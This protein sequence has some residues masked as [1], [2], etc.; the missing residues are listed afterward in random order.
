MFLI[1]NFSQLS[2]EQCVAPAVVIH[3]GF[4]S[5]MT[6]TS[7]LSFDIWRNVTAPKVCSS[8]GRDLLTYGCISWGLPLA[9]IAVAFV[10][11]RTAPDST[12][13]PA[14]GVRACW[15]G[16]TGG[17]FLYFLAPMAALTLF[18]VLLYVRTVCYIRRTSSNAR[19]R[20]KGSG[21]RASFQNDHLTLFLRLAII[22]GATWALEFVGYFLAIVEIDLV[23][24]A[25]VGL[26]GAY[27][28]FAFRDYRY[29]CG[30]VR[31]QATRS[32]SNSP[33]ATSLANTS[34]TRKC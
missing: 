10:V 21:I 20:E 9:V 18:C 7:V 16:T 8:H 29:L 32:V 3:Y 15:I 28:F 26:E 4:L 34:S 2:A 33:R 22:M 25:L 13:S 30:P 23:V 19:S 24:N 6:W 11:D 14:Y 27:L 5:T 31:R 1:I 12:L 17:H